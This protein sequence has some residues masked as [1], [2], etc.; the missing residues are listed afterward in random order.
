MADKEKIYY[1]YT[2]HICSF[3]Y[4]KNCKTLDHKYFLVFFI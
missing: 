1:A 4:I 3:K 2:Y